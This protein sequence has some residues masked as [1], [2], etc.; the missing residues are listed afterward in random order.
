MGGK[1]FA[2]AAMQLIWDAGDRLGAA[3]VAPPGK[4]HLLYS[5]VPFSSRSGMPDFL[6]WRESGLTAAGN[7]DATWQFDGAFAVGMDK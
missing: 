5:V 6:V 2:G 3:I 4:R 7:F 1:S